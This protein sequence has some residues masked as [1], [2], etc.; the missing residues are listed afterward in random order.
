MIS[1]DLHSGQIQ[2]FFEK[3]VDHLTAMPVLVD[4]M[5]TLGDDLVVIS[6]DTGRVKVA[7]RYASE[8]AADLAI[9]HKRRVKNKKNVVESK[10]VMGDVDGRVCVLIDDMIDTGGTIVGAAELLAEKGAKEVFACT[11][12]GVFSDLSLI[13]I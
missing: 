11:T 9:V 3:P 2:G 13:H 10:D 7:E 5:K 8:L 12:H 1:V 6:P 4:Y